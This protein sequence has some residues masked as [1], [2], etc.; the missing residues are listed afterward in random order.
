MNRLLPVW[1]ILLAAPSVFCQAATPIQPIPNDRATE[2]YSIYSSLIPLG[3]TAAPGW[4]HDLW[5]VQETTITAIPDD[6]PC[7]PTAKPNSAGFTSGMNPHSA[8][9]PPDNQLQDYLDILLDFDKHCHEKF[10]LDSSAWHLRAPVH[11]LNREEQAQFQF[12]R[13][14]LPQTPAEVTNAAKFKGAPALYGF[15]EVYF[16]APHTVALVYATLWCGGM[17]GQGGWYAFG[18]QSGEWKPLR[19]GSN[20]WMS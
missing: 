8:V 7:E 5:L 9:H 16:N 12:S 14:K 13:F 19:W 17:C 3:E 1:L 2:S 15:S 4:P 11:V 10:A 20:S 6:Q 18:L